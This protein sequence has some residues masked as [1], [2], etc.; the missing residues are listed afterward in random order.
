M[1]LKRGQYSRRLIHQL[2]GPEEALQKR[3]GHQVRKLSREEIAEIER[4][5]EPPVRR[6]PDYRRSFYV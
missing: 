3:L 5:L 6:K 2:H 4:N 1:K